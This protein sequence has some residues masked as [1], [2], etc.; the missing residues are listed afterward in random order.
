[1]C[2]CLYPGYKQLKDTGHRHTMHNSCTSDPSIK[3]TCNIYTHCVRSPDSKKSTFHSFNLHRMR[4]Q[5]LICLIIN[6]CA[7]SLLLF[8][9]DLAWKS[10][11][12]IT[13]CL[14]LSHFYKESVFRHLAYRKQYCKISGL[15]LFLADIGFLSADHTD[16]VCIRK[17]S[18]NKNSVLC[19]PWSHHI[20]G[21]SFLF[22]H[23][24]FNS[25]PVHIAV[26]FFIHNCVTS[27]IVRN[28]MIGYSYRQRIYG[29][30]N[31]T[32]KQ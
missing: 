22:I 1:M 11:G 16:F 27:P 29:T 18:L 4:T 26:Y 8:L 13:F 30:L 3:I 20:S 12:I 2:S 6:T 24:S 28:T 25:R 31:V 9:C 21:S 5:L 15:V 10:I 23:N 7:E 19:D 32:C 14:C 17:K